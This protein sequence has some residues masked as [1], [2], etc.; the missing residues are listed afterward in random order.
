VLSSPSNL[1]LATI[2]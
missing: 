2:K 1:K